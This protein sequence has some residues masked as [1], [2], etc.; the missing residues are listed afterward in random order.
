MGN[1]CA[2]SQ[3]KETWETFAPAVN[4]RKHGK[5][6]R[7]QSTQGNMGNLCA[8]S[9]LK[10]TWET[11]APAVNSRKHG[12][13]LRQQSTQGNMGNLCASSQL[14]ETW[15]TFAP[16]VNSRKHG[17]PLRQ[18]STQGNMGNL[19]ASSQ[20]KETWETFAPAVNSRKHGKSFTGKATLSTLETTFPPH[21]EPSSLVHNVRGF[22]LRQEPEL[23]D[24]TRSDHGSN[25]QPLI[26]FQCPLSIS[27]RS[28]HLGSINPYYAPTV[29]GEHR[30]F[31]AQQRPPS[32]REH[33]ERTAPVVQL[34]TGSTFFHRE[35]IRSDAHRHVRR[36][37]RSAQ[38][39]TYQTQPF[40]HYS[41]G[42]THEVVMIE[43]KQAD[44]S[45]VKRG[46][47]SKCG[48]GGGHYGG[49]GGKGVY[50]G[51]GGGGGGGSSCSTCGGGYPSGSSSSSS[52]QSS[53]SAHASSGSW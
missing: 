1:R 14:K 47:C 43:E 36:G 2:S 33:K 5:P 48:G 29:F 41:N 39:R 24:G 50:G 16:A 18:Q 22:W 31:I 32:T 10:E 38:E 8:S 46:T 21:E 27:T 13:P 12:K 17:K 4:S 9:Q 37:T 25:K 35:S 26:G 30:P 34:G 11:F 51:S 7:Q 15:E 20:L 28:E 19:C 45:R 42:Q 40:L 52:A 44:G 23:N 49:G 6:L 3:L 53:S